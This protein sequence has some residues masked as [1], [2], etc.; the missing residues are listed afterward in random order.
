MF[1]KNPIYSSH[2]HVRNNLRFLVLTLLCL[3]F[4]SVYNTKISAQP[5]IV[6]TADQP[7]VWTLE[8]AHYLI[9]QMH[10]RNLDLKASPLNALD[11]NEINA[12]NVDALKTLLSVSAEFDQAK[13][14]NN[15][16]LKNTKDYQV[17]RKRELIARRDTL[18]DESLTLTRQISE[19]KI[20][21]IRTEKEED[22]QKLQAQI[23]ELTVVKGAVDAQ[24]VQLNAQISSI[25]SESSS[26]E[27]VSP[28]A[29]GKIDQTTY[30]SV[31]TATA[32]KVVD[33]FNNS[34]QLN[35][36]LRL[37]N[38][39]QMQYE[40]LSKQLTLLRDEVGAGERL[41]FMEI[42]QSVNSSYR[43]ANNVW[44]QTWW[45]ITG[46][47]Q[48]IVYKNGDMIV[49]CSA[50]F[51][52]TNNSTDRYNLST[53]EIAEN[54]S[55]NV[56]SEIE[57]YS[58]T[59]ELTEAEIDTSFILEF[60]KSKYKVKTAKDFKL[61]SPAKYE[62]V[63]EE[64]KNKG[65]NL[66]NL[67]MKFLEELNNFIKGSNDKIDVN[68]F[69]GKSKRIDQVINSKSIP[70]SSPL[71][72]R[73]ILAELFDIDLPQSTVQYSKRFDSKTQKQYQNR[74][75]RVVDLFPRQSSLN[76]NDLK[77]RSSSLSLRGVFKLLSGFG[78]QA[79]Y[80][81][82]R[83]RYSQYVQQELYASA[84]GKGSRE[85]GWTFNPMPGTDRLLSGVRTTYAI[86]VVPEDATAITLEA[87]GCYFP[88]NSSQPSNFSDDNW[89]KTGDKRGC[90]KQ[91][92]FIIPIP[93]GGSMNNNNF[94][95]S[96]I[97][98]QPVSKNKRAVV[99]VYGKNFSS[100]IGVLVNGV[101]LTQ[102]LGLG[103]PFIRDDSE[104]RKQA[105][106]EIQK[107]EVTG[108]FE[109]IGAEQIIT[110][111][112]VPD[113]EGTPT[114]TL[115]APGKSLDLNSLSRLR[116]NHAY[117]GLSESDFI[118]G[119]RVGSNKEEVSVDKA[120]A[121]LVAGKMNLIISGKNL[122]KVTTVYIN[123]VEK[124]LGAKTDPMFLISI[125][126]L[127]L[128]PKFE[129][130][131]QIILLTEAGTIN[132]DP[133]ANPSFEAEKPP[134]EEI[135]YQFDEARLSIE[136]DPALKWCKELPDGSIEARFELKG[137]GLKEGIKAFFAGSETKIT[138]SFNGKRATVS[139]S[140]PSPEQF[141]EIQ[142]KK[143]KLNATVN[144]FWTKPATG[145]LK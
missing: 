80:Q 62:E 102:A 68:L 31:F 134:P 18:Q 105:L 142:D 145:C 65:D 93:D 108:S 91:K 39:L 1:D 120:S 16:N 7:N 78:A 131:L 79:D 40:I 107:E 45:N 33:Q 20:K 15:K 41:I 50:V 66:S 73:I 8:Q 98:Y 130:N 143:L 21:L 82:T 30:D 86:L 55:K 72:R 44:A 135:K 97:S 2:F 96:G 94:W 19:L 117:Q 46:Y 124:K 83:E 29:A 27:S 122:N 123:G 53:S 71:F 104:T 28:G 89:Q 69:K 116:V 77:L 34:P 101:P 84:F 125:E 60:L 3:S 138:P 99:T 17:N 137:I 106:S 103:Q 114:I 95:V 81:R 100:Q 38:Y 10:R 14:E 23:D 112:K 129:K 54:V 49:P 56:D 141:L 76:V 118:F 52:K 109:R 64:N 11:A 51:D 24:V 63:E 58:A 26:Y 4:F 88:R 121:F 75:V 127:N 12:L 140:N 9:A 74:S 128:I 70:S 61:L 90:F 139:V 43:K 57:R 32:K 67:R 59:M 25:S 126:K 132:A 13:G 87:K 35:A 6:V 144:L 133:I 113:F 48:C 92:D 85:F 111:F 42:P 136:T 22:K 37:D 110:S 47:S 119:K 5:P 36:S 115:V